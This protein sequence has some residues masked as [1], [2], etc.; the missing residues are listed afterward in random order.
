ML[1]TMSDAQERRRFKRVK[2]PILCRPIGRPFGS[3]REPA[4]DIGRGGLRVYTDE[5]LKIGD[6][7][8]VEL[9]LP[10]GSAVTAKV[11][12]AWIETL[13]KDEPAG[14][15]VGLAFLDPTDPK[16]GKLSAVLGDEPAGQ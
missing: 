7:M 11:T 9:F 2:T 8:E 12:V 1:A 3:W 16:L 13:E 4:Q 10:D 15:D 6:A 5:K 14:F